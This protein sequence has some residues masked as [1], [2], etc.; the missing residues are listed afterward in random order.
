MKRHLL[1]EEFKLVTL[2][3][4]LW[5]G[6]DPEGQ[7]EALAVGLLRLLLLAKENIFQGPSCLLL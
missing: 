2:D 4:I 6:G 7:E 1:V 3:Q 5:V